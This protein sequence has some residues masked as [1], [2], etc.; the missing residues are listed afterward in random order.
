MAKRCIIVGGGVAGL[1]AGSYLAAWGW[2]VGLYERRPTLAGRAGG[3]RDRET[4]DT[5][6]TGPHLI[7][8]LLSR[9]IPLPKTNRRKKKPQSLPQDFGRVCLSRRPDRNA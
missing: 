3:Y 4:G 7:A 2:Q 9:N 8:W 1:A 6:D 5:L